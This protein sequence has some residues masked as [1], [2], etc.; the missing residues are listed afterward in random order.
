MVRVQVIAGAARRGNAARG[1]AQCGELRGGDLWRIVKQR[2]T[3]IAIT[4][5]VVYVLIVAAT[6]LVYR[7]APLYP[8]EAYVRLLPPKEGL[9]EA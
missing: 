9:E 4:F 8:A 5:S 7:Y 1:R 3:L 6:F 2:L